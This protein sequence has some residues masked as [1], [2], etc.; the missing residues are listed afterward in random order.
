MFL[1]EFLVENRE[2][3]HGFGAGHIG[4]GLIDVLL[5]ESAHRI[6]AAGLS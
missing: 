4:I 6:V 5:H 3:A 1:I 2:L